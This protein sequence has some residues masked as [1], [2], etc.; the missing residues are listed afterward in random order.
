[1]STAARLV[2]AAALASLGATGCGSDRAT[3]ATFAGGWQG[4]TRSLVITRNGHAREWLYSG[5]C[6]LGIALRFTLS[7]PAGTP[8]NATARATVTAVQIGHH[9]QIFR[10]AFRKVG[11]GDSFSIRLR[12][13]VISETL[14]GIDYCSLKAK[15]WVCGA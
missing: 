4:H 14:T 10:T 5:C 11:V 15:H 9:D 7:D 1:V 8:N 3:L 13:G 6:Y 12:E 2:T